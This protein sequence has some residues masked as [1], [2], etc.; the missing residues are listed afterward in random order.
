M[1]VLILATQILEVAVCLEV[2]GAELLKINL[3]LLAEVSN[4][5]HHAVARV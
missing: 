4:L 2:R 1:Q 5:W 3:L